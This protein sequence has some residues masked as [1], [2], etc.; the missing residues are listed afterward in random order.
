MRKLLFLLFLFGGGMTAASQ[1]TL[2][3]MNG[4]V[5]DPSGAVVPKARVVLHRAES[6][7]DRAVVAGGGWRVRCTEPGA[8]DV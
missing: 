2:A 4:T 8:G 6:N 5:R 1:S 3:S 7:T